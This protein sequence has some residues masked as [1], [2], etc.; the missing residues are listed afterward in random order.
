MDARAGALLVMTP[1]QM[2]ATRR[3]EANGVKREIDF[4]ILGN[5]VLM[6]IPK[7]TGPRTTFAVARHSAIPLTIISVPPTKYLTRRGVAADAKIV[8]K[9]VRS[10]LNATF[11]P[12]MKHTRLLAVPPGEHPTRT[13]PRNR[14]GSTPRRN[15]DPINQAAAGIIPN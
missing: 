2:I 4:E 10:T 5:L 13:S 14:E 1:P 15:F 9:V 3:T 8:E 12:A 7:R 11:A 6:S